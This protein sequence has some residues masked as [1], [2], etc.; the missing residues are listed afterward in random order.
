MLQ[1]EKEAG[2][3]AVGPASFLS[4]DSSTKQLTIFL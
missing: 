3:A 1:Y 4:E 2:P